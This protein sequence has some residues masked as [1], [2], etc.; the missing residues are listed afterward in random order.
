MASIGALTDRLAAAAL[1]CAKLLRLSV[2]LHRSHDTLEIPVQKL[3][4]SDGEMRLHLPKEWLS[5]H[6]LTQ[7]DLDT[8]IDYLRA[9]GQKLELAEA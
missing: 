3:E 5:A 9:Q 8:E 6:P 2:L 1:H 7:A 4:A